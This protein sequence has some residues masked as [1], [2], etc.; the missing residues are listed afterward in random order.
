LTRATQ[1]VGVHP[2]GARLRVEAASPREPEGCIRNTFN[3]GE[4]GAS[5]IA[6]LRR[7]KDDATHPSRCSKIQRGDAP[8]GTVDSPG[9]AKPNASEESSVPTYEYKCDAC[10]HD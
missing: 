7:G 1:L 5:F 6:S 2:P 4:H 9:D 10:A 8:L 3:Q